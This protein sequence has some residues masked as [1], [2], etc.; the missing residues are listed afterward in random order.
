MKN[1]TLHF[2][3]NGIKVLFCC[4]LF[5]PTT[6]WAQNHFDVKKFLL[7]NPQILKVQLHSLFFRRC[8]VYTR[9]TLD[10]YKAA[11]ETVALLDIYPI[12]IQSQTGPINYIVNF[13]KNLDEIISSQT[14]E[15]LNQLEKDL[16]QLSD[17]IDT[18]SFIAPHM[19]KP[20]D[21]GELASHYFSTRKQAIKVLATL[22][23]DIDPSNTQIRYLS[24]QIGQTSNLKKVFS[25]IK[26]MSH[27]PNVGSH[28]PLKIFGYSFPNNKIYHVLVPAYLSQELLEK[29]HSQRVSFA[30]PFF[31]NYIYEAAEVNSPLQVYFVEPSS[32]SNENAAQDIEA[33]ELGAF[34]GIGRPDLKAS[35]ETI[36]TKLK[37]SPISYLAELIRVR[38][39]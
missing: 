1:G 17:E 22:F 9:E 19:I 4:L 35:S 28:Y 12:Q 16:T 3:W 30:V 36:R 25:V 6:L 26:L 31:L 23:Q 20:V 21:L 15:F 33:G 8:S 7:E 13:K 11:Q 2:R 18:Y 37:E 14:L 38:I 34:I 5:A 39:N 29:G 32:I 10:C 24:S 27:I